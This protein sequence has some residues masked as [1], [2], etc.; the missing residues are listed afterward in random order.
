MMDLKKILIVDDD[1]ELGKALAI[2]LKY[3]GY[4]V[5]FAVDGLSATSA[6]R[7]YDPDLILLDLGLPAGDGFTVMERLQSMASIIP[8]IVYSAREPNMNKDRALKLGAEAY[9]QKPADNETLLGAIKRA[10]GE[11]DLPMLSSQQN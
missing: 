6:V 7:K 9:Y 4:S 2:R 10:L 3:N 1:Q 11:S 5:C 8:V